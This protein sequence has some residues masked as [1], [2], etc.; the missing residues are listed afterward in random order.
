MKTIREEKRGG[1]TFR[2]VKKNTGAKYG[3]IVIS[4][5]KITHRIDGDDDGQVWRDLLSAAGDNDPGYFGFDGAVNRFREF[6]PEEF[7][8]DSYIDKERREKD[9]AKKMLNE[10][11]PLDAAL[12]SSVDA[13]SVVR[14]FQKLNLLASFEKI[15]VKEM[16]EGKNG[17]QFIHGAAVMACGNTEAG[18][19]EMSA[20]AKPHGA[21]KWTA[22]TY[23]P[24]LWRPEEHMY[25]KPDATKDFADRVGHSFKNKYEAGLK[26]KV[27]E[28]LCD[29]AKTTEKELAPLKPRDWI[30]VQSFIWVVGNYTESEK[31]GGV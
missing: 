22:A 17:G 13:A 24:Y 14:V 29:L 15:K 3:G 11:A 18:L 12:D 20:A 28:S 21:D 9:A 27:Y 25:L 19:R 1:K 5:G 16:L 31:Y 10:L 8:S 7:L 4:G 2:L 6:F 26:P 23:L 30:D